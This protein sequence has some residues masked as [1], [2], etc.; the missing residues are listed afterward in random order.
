MPPTAGLP[1]GYREGGSWS[2]P[3][4]AG[5]LASTVEIVGAGA[6]APLNLAGGLNAASSLA[7]SG[8][9]SAEAQ[10]IVSAVA[11]LSG[12]GGL[13]P[14][15]AGKLDASITLAGSGAI[16]GAL[17]ALAGAVAEIVGSGTLAA[18]G[19]GQGF[20]SADIQPFTELSP[21]SLA[22]AV[23]NALVA[24]FDAVGTFGEAV[25]AGGGGGG[26][27]SAAAIADAVWDESTSA[28]TSAAT[29]GG[30]VQGTIYTAKLAVFDDDGAG[31]DRYVVTWFANGA[32]VTSGI[33]LPSIRVV[34]VA[35]GTDLVPSSTMTEIASGLS[36]YRYDA[37]T[38][39]RVVSGA[40]YIALLSATIDGATRTWDQPVGRDST[41]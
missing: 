29:F 39:Q 1:S 30:L 19:R 18:T 14:S 27:P 32:P 9:L 11:A 7:G 3:Q 6:V 17:A 15:I 2:L 5:E 31:M 22:A 10:L 4:K 40:A 24:D 8:A 38:T 35:D 37:A 16:S 36:R 41:T 28:H 20:I 23:W 13:S 34:R 33:T 26:G 25:Q 12:L 21:Q